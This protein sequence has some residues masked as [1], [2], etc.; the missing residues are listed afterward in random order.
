MNMTRLALAA[1]AATL[2]DA[3]YGFL[4]Y[5]TALN[6]AF[7]AFPAV[8]RSA[9]TGPAYLPGMFAGILIAMFAVTFIYAKGYEG[10]SGVKEGMRFGLLIAIFVAGGFV[11]VNYAI[12]NISPRLAALMALAGLGE[13]ILVGCTIGLVYKP[14]AA[15]AAS[16]RTAKV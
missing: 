16:R 1:V 8:F 6:S 5:G 13:W 12:L 9:E 10:G 3:V 2:V 7:L 4:V 14:S 11:G 15:G